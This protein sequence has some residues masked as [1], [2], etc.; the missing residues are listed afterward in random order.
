M[1]FSYH[2]L[3][4][5]F[6]FALF[7]SYNPTLCKTY[8]YSREYLLNNHLFYIEPPQEAFSLDIKPISY[9]DKCELKQLH[10]IS[11]RGNYLFRNM[12][13]HSTE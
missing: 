9:P 12:Y 8:K 7:V 3:Y 6:I 10:L 13:K 11:R 4:S 1:Q 2:I 5:V